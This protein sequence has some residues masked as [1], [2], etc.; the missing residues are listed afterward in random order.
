MGRGK[1]DV[2]RGRPLQ[3]IASRRSGLRG[4]LG[5]KSSAVIKI[6]DPFAAID[7]G[8]KEGEEASE[9]VISENKWQFETGIVI[10]GKS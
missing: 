7:M 3:S 4:G 6:G 2:G 9:I 10:N 8:R 1:L 5:N